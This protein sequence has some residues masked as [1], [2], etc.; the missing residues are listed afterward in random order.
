[1]S[2]EWDVYWNRDYDSTWDDEENEILE[3][4]PTRTFKWGASWSASAARDM[5]NYRRGY[6]GKEEP[7]ND[8]MLNLKFYKNEIMFEPNG[9]YIDDILA[10]WQ[11]QYDQLERN[12]SYIQ[13]LF[14]LQE[15]GMNWCAKPLTQQE[16]EALKS[17]ENAKRRFCEAY[18]L[19]LDFYGIKLKDEKTGEVV[20]SNNYIERFNNLNR[21]GHNNL[22]ITRILKCLGELG[23]EH[24]Q[25]PLVQFFLEETLVNKKLPNVKRSTLDY[26]MFTVKDRKQRK[27]LV[28]YAWEKLEDKG[29][30]IWG[31]HRYLR[32]RTK[33]STDSSI[34]K[35]N[36][37]DEE[38]KISEEVKVERNNVA[39]IAAASVSGTESA[40]EEQL[41]DN[42]K[43]EKSKSEER[44]ENVT[45][46]ILK[47]DQA[48]EREQVVTGESSLDKHTQKELPDT[49]E[50]E[51]V[52]EGNSEI[53]DLS[54]EKSEIQQ[55]GIETEHTV[56]KKEK[57]KGEERSENV[58]EIIL[59]KDK[60]DEREQEVTGESSL[61]KYTQK[62]LPHT[63]ETEGVDEDEG[64]LEI[65]DLSEGK[66][67]IQQTCIETKHTVEK[68]ENSKSEERSENVTEII[69]KKDQADERE[70]EVTGESS[71]DKNTQ[72]ELPDTSETEGVDEGNSEIRD[73]SEE[74]SE[75]Q[76]AGI[77]TEHTVKKKE[78]SKGEELSENVTGIILKKDKADERE[79]VTGESSLDNNKQKEL[80][81]TSETEG[82]DEDEGNSE[83]R[84]LSE[85]K[86]EI[87]QAGI[88][89]KHTVEKKE[90]SKGEERL[91]NVTEI[92]LK[93][94][95]AD[96]REQ[97]TGESSL[98]TNTQK[99]L[100]HIPET[101]VNDK[102]MSE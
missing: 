101:E 56:E 4:D 29:R 60:A 7:N 87:Q 91:E 26:F 78:K 66:S 88:E 15:M 97:V 98:D 82:V 50:T 11:G 68:K 39:N 71:L 92:I 65:R 94:D 84:D 83:I 73:L 35:D 53:R 2:C 10:D 36:T 3:P 96:E 18:R 95:K 100:P 57:S 47:K 34:N 6:P 31:P 9:V 21:H 72:K 22:R 54:E 27:D 13:W 86:S 45:E 20:R 16:I 102:P 81:H 55:A 77:E 46:I 62:E 64:N 33:K 74:K 76:Q 85:E 61:D 52:D 75:I 69:L 67:E 19:M 80:Q 49:S 8:E 44:S 41:G 63:S 17:D 42:E 48:D 99:V 32:K 14:P 58:T 5:Q 28:L 93:K 25:A 79:Q 70:Q 38:S 12:H 40:T 51:G 30:F 23:Y 37:E 89:T 90:K 59:K 43:E 24:F 1:M